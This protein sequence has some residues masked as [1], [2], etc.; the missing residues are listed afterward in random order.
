MSDDHPSYIPI[1]KN[2]PNVAP[3]PDAWNVYL[4]SR[5]LGDFLWEPGICLLKAKY[6]DAVKEHNFTGIEFRTV[7]LFRNKNCTI[8]LDGYVELRVTA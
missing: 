2:N 6:V 3:I 5:A 1:D 8:P 4:Y 7:N